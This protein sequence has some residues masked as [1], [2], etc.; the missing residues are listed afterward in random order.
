MTT[1]SARP[2]ALDAAADGLRTSSSRL[3]DAARSMWAAADAY[4]ELCPDRPLDLVS[5]SRVGAAAAP[6]LAP[7]IPAS[8]VSI[9]IAA[10]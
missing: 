1:S 2:D 9:P 5:P 10:G 7:R 8:I 6:G 3:H 4:R